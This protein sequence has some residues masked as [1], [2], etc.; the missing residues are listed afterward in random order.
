MSRLGS[1]QLVLPGHFRTNLGGMKTTMDHYEG[2]C[3]CNLS[4]NNALLPAY[5]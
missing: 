2:A 1:P 4:R 5:E 3:S